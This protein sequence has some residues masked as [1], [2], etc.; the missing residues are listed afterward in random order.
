MNNTYYYNGAVSAEEYAALL[1]AEQESCP[2]PAGERSVPPGCA[3]PPGCSPSCVCLCRPVPCPQPIQVEEGCCCQESFR[4]ALGLL[5]DEELADLLDPDVAAF[6]TRDFIVG[7]A[8]TAVVGTD[9]PADNLTAPLAGSFRGVAA[10]SCDLLEVDGGV[11][12]PGEEASGLTAS[13]VNL[14][15]LAAAVIQLAAVNAEG[16][17]TAEEVAA[18][19]FRR[20]RRIL[21][22][23]IS[24]C[25][26]KAGCGGEGC[27]GDCCCAD[28]VMAAL[29]T[30]CLSRRV[31]LTAGPLILSGVTL[32]GAVGHVL[33]LANEDAQRFYFVCANEVDI[34][35]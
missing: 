13:R 14:C 3:V 19:N 28:G 6:V 25:G 2:T 20:V 16:D 29:G 15:R 30:G 32:I 12:V 4:A 23:R 31:S 10:C 18:R 1:A 9:T 5:C 33:V 34:L 17:L 27:C 21:S 35:A 8:S 7:A 26:A 11:Y 24:P 22:R